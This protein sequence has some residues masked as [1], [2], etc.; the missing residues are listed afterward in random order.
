M[1]IRGVSRAYQGTEWLI[2]DLLDSLFTSRFGLHA[3]ALGATS[4][5]RVVDDL[6]ALVEARLQELFK[7]VD[8][9][10]NM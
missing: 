8:G 3:A 7:P 4:R 2:T 5:F 9:E 10:I 1:R 6:N